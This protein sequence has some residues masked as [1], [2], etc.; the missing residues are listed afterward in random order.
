MEELEVAEEATNMWVAA[1]YT[2]EPLPPRA[3]SDTGKR[4]N[5]RMGGAMR[6]APKNVISWRARGGI[7]AIKNELR[8]GWLAARRTRESADVVDDGTRLYNSQ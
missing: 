6:K 8:V 1:L 2:S 7:N 4:V 5:V 3:I